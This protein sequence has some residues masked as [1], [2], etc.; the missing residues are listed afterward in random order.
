[1]AI[2]CPHRYYLYRIALYVLLYTAYNLKGCDSTWY[3][4]D[5]FTA[6]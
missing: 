3:I 4:L 1:M 2:T 5:E 6:S